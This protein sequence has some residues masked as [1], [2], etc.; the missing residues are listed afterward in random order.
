[1]LDSNLSTIQRI[2]TFDPVKLLGVQE[3]FSLPVE[4]QSNVWQ[5]TAHLD[6]AFTSTT[7]DYRTH[8]L[9]NV[10]KNVR[11]KQIAAAI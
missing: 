7:E 5:F 3:A 10:S 6:L 11:A 9:D 8:L 2:R 1:M 4:L